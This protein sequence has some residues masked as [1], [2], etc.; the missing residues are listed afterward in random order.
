MLNS[1]ILTKSVVE[2]LREKGINAT[3]YT[4][5]GKVKTYSTA[6]KGKKLTFK[7]VKRRKVK[8]PTVKKVTVK[9][10]TMKLKSYAKITTPKVK[11][12]YLNLNASI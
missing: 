3:Q 8:A 11:K 2:G 6:K 7:Q 4:E 9:K 12:K 1:D 10:P 5:A